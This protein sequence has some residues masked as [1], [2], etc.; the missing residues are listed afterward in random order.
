[1][2]FAFPLTYYGNAYDFSPDLSTI[3]YVT[4][5]GQSDFYFQEIH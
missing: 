2:P 4:P 3:L 1:L 5:S